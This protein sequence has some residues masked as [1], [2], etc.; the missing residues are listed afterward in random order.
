MADNKTQE[1][2]S[3]WIEV[4]LKTEEPHKAFFRIDEIMDFQDSRPQSNEIIILEHSGEDDY[5]VAGTDAKQFRKRLEKIHGSALPFVRFQEPSN[6]GKYTT[7]F[8]RADRIT[9]CENYTYTK[10]VKG[11]EK[12]KTGC[13]IRLDDTSHSRSGVKVEMSPKDFLEQVDKILDGME[14]TCEICCCEEDD[15]E[16][17]LPEEETDDKPGNGGGGGVAPI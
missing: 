12:T 14:Q 8:L 15:D 4:E 1:K 7:R 16:I 13:V 6:D 9:S 10:D 17:P 3:R 2:T 5:E 11:E